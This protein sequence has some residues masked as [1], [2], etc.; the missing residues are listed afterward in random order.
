MAQHDPHFDSLRQISL[1]TLIPAIDGRR[2]PSESTARTTYYA[3]PLGKLQVTPGDDGLDRYHFWSGPCAGKG[4][5][6]AISFV[7]DVG[8][9]KGFQAVCE[10]LQHHQPPSPPRP[11][12]QRARSQSPY[13]RPQRLTD[14]QATA[15]ASVRYLSVRRGIPSAVIR[16]LLR[17]PHP[18]IAVGQGAKFGRYLIFPVRDHTD[19]QKP[20]VGAILRWSGMG[21]PPKTL[22][23]GAKAPKAPGTHADRGW[24]QVGPYPAGTV[25]VTEAPIDALSLWSALTPDARQTTR[26]LATGGQGGLTAP[27]LWRGTERLILAQDRDESGHQ[28]ALDAWQSAYD[29]GCRASVTRLVPPHT[30]WNA[31]WRA[32]PKATQQ[33]LTQALQPSIKSR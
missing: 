3:T 27:G 28:Q 14:P 5:R 7:Q 29:A 16:D 21:T 25:I 24:W 15:S 19:P 6:G 26:I 20:E 11:L 1:D 32:D 13:V 22:F 30:D 33:A 9:A 12:V 17:N 8:L 23:G 4:N 18:P 31:A 10:Y 2:I